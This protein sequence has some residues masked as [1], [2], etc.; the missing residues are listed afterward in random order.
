VQLPALSDKRDGH[1]SANSLVKLKDI[2]QAEV[3][4]KL[5]LWTCRR[6]FGQPLLD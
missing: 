5:D 4:F 1:F 6:T 2:V 3:G